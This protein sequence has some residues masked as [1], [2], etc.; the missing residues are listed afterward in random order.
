MSSVDWTSCAQNATP[1]QRIET[2]TA[3]ALA[4][5][6]SPYALVLAHLSIDREGAGTLPQDPAYVTEYVW[7]VTVTIHGSHAH[8]HVERAS[9]DG[10]VADCWQGP[11]TI[12]IATR[13]AR[14]IDRML[15]AL[16]EEGAERDPF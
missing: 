14:A 12:G 10:H 16:W 9:S 15:E 4:P 2:A 6:L 13:S 8:L 7:T 5:G 1:E 11:A 3:P